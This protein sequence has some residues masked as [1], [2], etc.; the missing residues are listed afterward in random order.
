MNPCFITATHIL[1]SPVDVPGKFA[2]QL[3][4]A[5]RF[6]RLGVTAADAVLVLAD[7]QQE[8]DSRTGLFVGT[9]FGPMQ[10]N[11]D[12]LGLIVDENQTS[13]T[14]FS[15]SVFNSAAGYIAR[16]FQISGSSFSFT[17]FSFPFFQALAEGYSAIVTGRLDN[18]LVLQVETYSELL[19][20]AR[21][22]TGTGA[23]EWPQGAVAWYLTNH[24]GGAG[25]VLEK[26][27][28]DACASA[29]DDLLH[30]QE[31]LVCGEKSETCTTPLTA[32]S[33]LSSLLQTQTSESRLQ[34][35]LSASY[36]S[37]SLTFLP[38]TG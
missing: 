33:A 10:T 21:K 25:S 35:L 17:G 12:V 2:A 3:R 26:I 38:H 19:H 29:P 27:D 15:H 36:G 6:I 11:F 37:V 31:K 4:R 13:P 1:S 7:T 16:L 28:I 9:A 32:A 34:C 14:L 24:D 18:C 5:D 23:S 30:R 22:S 8:P 20:D